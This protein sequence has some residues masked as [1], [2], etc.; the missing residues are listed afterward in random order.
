MWH[1]FGSWDPPEALNASSR[2]RFDWADKLKLYLE[3]SEA[4]G[5]LVRNLIQWV[6]PKRPTPLALSPLGE[7]WNLAL[8]RFDSEGG[9]A[10]LKV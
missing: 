9:V 7:I 8:M 2:A 6:G 4:W 10:Q 3:H 1:P 5:C